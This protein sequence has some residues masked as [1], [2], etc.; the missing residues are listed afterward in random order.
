MGRNHPKRR[1]GDRANAVL[2]QPATTSACSC[3]G[4]GAFVRLVIATARDAEALISSRQRLEKRVT[5]AFFTDDLYAPP[6]EE[7]SRPQ[8]ATSPVR[9]PI[10]G[11]YAPPS[12]AAVGLPA[13]EEKVDTPLDCRISKGAVGRGTAANTDRNNPGGH[14]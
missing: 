3:A 10:R 14:P 11:R 6:L 7:Q 9:T 5:Y 12:E 13:W 2:L 1:E 4:S 8:N